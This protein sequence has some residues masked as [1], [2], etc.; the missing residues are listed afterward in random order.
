MQSAH[1]M[2][3]WLQFLKHT[4]F[5]KNPHHILKNAHGISS[6]RTAKLAVWPCLDFLKV[7]SSFFFAVFEVDLWASLGPVLPGCIPCKLYAGDTPT[8]TI[9]SIAICQT[10]AGYL[11]TFVHR[12]RPGFNPKKKRSKCRHKHPP[13]K[14]RNLYAH[15]PQK[16][17]FQIPSEILVHR[18][19]CVHY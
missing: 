12:M 16:W 4:H 10:H 2:R 13:Q 7:L 6:V 17:L 3:T 5:S 1:I 11:R 14:L 8:L 9:D 18:G 15:N 19:G